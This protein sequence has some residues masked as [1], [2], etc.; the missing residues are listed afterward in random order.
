MIGQNPPEA[1]PMIAS[2]SLVSRVPIF[3]KSDSSP[4]RLEHFLKKGTLT[5]ESKFK[6]LE[7]NKNPFV[8][9]LKAPSLGPS[10][11]QCSQILIAD[12]DPFQ[13]LYYQNLFEKSQDT[14]S[15]DFKRQGS[16][17]E[18][19]SSGEELIKRFSSMKLCACNK[20]RVIIT[21]YQMGDNKLNG[22]ETAKKLR[23]MG[24]KGPLLM[25]TSEKLDELAEFHP[26]LPTIVNCLIEKSDIKQGKETILKYLK[27]KMT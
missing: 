21:D 27:Q 13:H 18:L 19:F 17:V 6:Q 3:G 9:Y 24:Y 4:S 14:E 11:C 26:Y 22:A 16:S 7:M 20:L 1:S 10:I 8:K 15:S 25:R 12:D 2:E 5:E 23:E